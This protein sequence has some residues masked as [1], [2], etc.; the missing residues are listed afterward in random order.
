MG[1]VARNDVIEIRAFKIDL[2]TVDE[3]RF[4]V[5]LRDGTD[6]EL[7]EEHPAFGAF[8]DA[9]KV[10]FPAIEGWENRVIQPAFATNMTVLFRGA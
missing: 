7:S 2:F 4:A 9:L 5:S 1:I 6:F 10:R 8:V 3:V